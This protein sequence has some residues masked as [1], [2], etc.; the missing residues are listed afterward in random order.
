[1]KKKILVSLLLVFVLIQ[2]KTVDKTN[3][4]IV[5]ENDFLEMTNA[6]EGVAELMHEVCYDCHSHQVRYP[7]YANIAPVSWWLKGHVETGLSKA[8]FADWSSYSTIEK[9]S[10]LTRSSRLVGLKWMPIITYKITHSEARLTEEQ[11]NM[12]IEF[13]EYQRKLLK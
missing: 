13:F 8:N 4:P 12:L 6:P 3:P 11:R 7:W 2:F 1:M 10:V 5:P 9:D